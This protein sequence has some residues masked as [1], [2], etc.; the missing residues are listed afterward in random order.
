MAIRA[1]WT[2]KSFANNN[3]KGIELNLVEFF[4]ISK[5]QN[6]PR[7]RCLRLGKTLVIWLKAYI[8]KKVAIRLY[9]EQVIDMP[10][11]CVQTNEQTLC[12]IL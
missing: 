7:P 3:L 10:H 9:R 6:F 1:S 5:N 12:S 11:K 2:I 4:D 8:Q